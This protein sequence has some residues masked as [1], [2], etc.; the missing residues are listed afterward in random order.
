MKIKLSAISKYCRKFG[1]Y[2]CRRYID[3]DVYI[4][5]LWRRINDNDNCTTITII[6]TVTN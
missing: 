4:T 5:G 2:K 6:S 3:S 1:L